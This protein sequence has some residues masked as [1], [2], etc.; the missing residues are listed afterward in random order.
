MQRNL[1]PAVIPL[2]APY[3]NSYRRLRSRLF[4]APINLEWGRDNRTTGLRVPI[5]EPAAR[6]VEDRRIFIFF[7]G[8]GLQPLSRTFAA[9]LFRSPAAWVGLIEENQEPLR[10][11]HGGLPT[12]LKAGCPAALAMRWG[13]LGANPTI[14]QVLGGE[15]C[16]VYSA[17]KELEYNRVFFRSISPWERE[18]LLLNV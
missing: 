5:T 2:L 13:L 15:F 1:G 7:C 3:V 6:R 16:R 17:V 9:Y 18:H 14:Q 10:S 11:L 8:D 4:A 12:S